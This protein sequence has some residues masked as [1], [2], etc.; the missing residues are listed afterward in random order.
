M[1]V[2]KTTTATVTTTS[3]SATTLWTIA[4]SRV[5]V[6]AK[7][8]KYR[9]GLTNK[10]LKAFTVE[11]IHYTTFEAS[12]VTTSSTVSNTGDGTDTVAFVTNGSNNIELQVTAESTDSTIWVAEI[13]Y[14]DE[15]A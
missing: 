10:A 7:V 5:A 3:T 6:W 2:I 4:S 8:S 1:A 13:S 12:E 11:G 14:I 15:N 9:N